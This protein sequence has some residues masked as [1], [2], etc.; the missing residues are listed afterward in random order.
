MAR[1]RYDDPDDED[2]DHEDDYDPDDPETYP[3]GLYED[4]DIPTVPCPY[5]VDPVWLNGV[6]AV[7][8]VL[9]PL[10]AS[11][12]RVAF[13]DDVAPVADTVE[14]TMLQLAVPVGC[15]L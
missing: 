8:T 5:C 13:V 9:P 15:A 3:S 11:T 7:F 14:L 12:V 4:D 10:C 1:R 6:P 2:D